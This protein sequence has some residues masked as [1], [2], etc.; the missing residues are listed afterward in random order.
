MGEVYLAEHLLLRRPCAIKLI[1]PER[2]GNLTNL[3]RF[4]REV[5]VT[6]TLTHPNTVEI[7]DYGHAD[8]GTFYYV[9]EYLPGLSLDQLVGRHGPLAPERVVHL[10]TQ[11]C[12]ALQEAHSVGLIHRDIKPG[13]ILVCERGGLH[14]VAKLLDFGLVQAHGL[15]RED[16][17]LTQEG[18]IAGTPAFMSPE[19]AA[20]RSDLDVRS[21]VYSLG[22]VGYFLLTGHPPFVRQTAVQTLAAHIYESP[23]LPSREADVPADLEAVVL[24]C[25]EKDATGRFPDAESMER[26][27]AQ[28]GCAGRWTHEQATQWWLDQ[29]KVD[30]VATR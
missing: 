19:Q 22:A 20:G 10:L 18:A 7:F 16:Q 4:E 8:D 15:E 2:A 21:D 13:N 27:L 24:R 30:R 12:S 9:M 1:R 29:S 5:Q 14:D 25:L 26:A 3:A 28:C 23:A 6:A 11:V 17:K